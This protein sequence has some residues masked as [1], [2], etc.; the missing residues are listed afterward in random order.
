MRSHWNEIGKSAIGKDVVDKAFTSYECFK[1]SK[2][3][4][5]INAQ[6]YAWLAVVSMPTFSLFQPRLHD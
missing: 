4:K 6:N 2:D 5:L 3:D 1:L